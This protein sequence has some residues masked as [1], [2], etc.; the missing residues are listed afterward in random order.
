M[1]RA[2]MEYLLGKRTL[3]LTLNGLFVRCANSLSF[4]FPTLSFPTDT[5]HN[6]EDPCFYFRG[7]TLFT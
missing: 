1:I 6:A 4:S 3:V 7:V 2:Q 5:D